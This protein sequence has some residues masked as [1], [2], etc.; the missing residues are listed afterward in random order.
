MPDRTDSVHGLDAPRR[1]SLT[2][3][4]HQTSTFVLEDAADVDDVYEGR[5]EGDVYTRYSNPT[6]RSVERR[7]AHVERTEAALVFGSGMA[8]ISAVAL[9]FVPA[10]G[11]I[12]ANADLY[13]GTLNLLKLLRERHGVRVDFVPTADAGAIRRA[14]REKTDLLY[15]ETPTNPTLRLVDLVAAAEA[16]RAAGVV[17]A[18]DSTFAT[19]VNSRPHELGIDVVI[20]SATKYLGGHADISAGVACAAK[21]ITGRVHAT[22]KLLGAVLDPHAAFLLERGLQTL[23]LRV[24]AA[25]ENAQQLAEHLARHPAVH[26][27][28]YPGLASH[29]QHALA[30]RQMPGGFG[31]VLSFDLATLAEAKRFLDELKLVRNAASLGGVESL[32]SIPYQQSHRNQPRDA[33]AASGITEGTV[34]LA[35]G[36]EDAEDIVE[37]VDRALAAV[38]KR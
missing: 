19:P 16:A 9:T 17:S 33:L 27:V 25:N 1:G 15:L 6:L 29:P 11:R 24:Q 13:G 4:I 10:G 21:E 28:H 2:T 36:V 32:C 22:H 38:A 35:L 20:H 12:V 5:R 31:G 26:A 8:A 14:L 18:V 23:P 7:L 30:K 37:D 3:P 34:R